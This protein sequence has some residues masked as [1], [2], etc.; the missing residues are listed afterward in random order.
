[1][2]R[3]N[4]HEV[5]N[6]MLAERGAPAEDHPRS[7]PAPDL[8]LDA[9]T[10]GGSWSD[11]IAPPWELLDGPPSNDDIRSDDGAALGEPD[12]QTAQW[13]AAERLYW[14]TRAL[15]EERYL[16]T[17]QRTLTFMFAEATSLVPPLVDRAAHIETCWSWINLAI[18]GYY[19]GIAQILSAQTAEAAL[20]VTVQRETLIAADPGVTIASARAITT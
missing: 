19:E 20:A 4:P 12:L 9:D 17:T 16:D 18:D 11:D 2:D 3:G 8:G 15:V 13:I 10:N 6:A 7:L 5:I 1:M 14:T